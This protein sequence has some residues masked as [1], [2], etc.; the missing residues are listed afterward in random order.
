[1]QG[2]AASDFL[3]G[4]SDNDL[5][6]AWEG[7]DTLNGGRGMDRMY[8][9]EG[10]DVYF[11]DT[12]ADRVLEV[13]LDLKDSG[14]YD[15]VLARCTF[16]LGSHVEALKL[17]GT[18]GLQGYGNALD[19]VI[20]GNRGAN[21]LDGGAG[22]DSLHGGLG[23][24]RLTGGEGKDT[25]VG[26]RG[27]DV[28]DVDAAAHTAIQQNDVDVVADFV[29]GQDRIDFSQVDADPS[30]ND[31]DDAFTG[32]IDASEIFSAAGQLRF[33]DGV[34]YGNTDGDRKAEFAIVLTGITELS[35]AD[36]V[37]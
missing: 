31:V 35:A 30:T 28:F 12:A 3:L 4:S 10:D 9:G 15:S 22:D 33:E 18:A 19:N 14:G 11:V 29:R 32:F 36:L 34:L 17:L 5:I 21:V 24:D 7:D 27:S 2:T 23:D 6:V 16:A 26:G 8:G 37:L 20:K 25:L 1:M 13:L